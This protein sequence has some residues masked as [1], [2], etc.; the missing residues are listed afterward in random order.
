MRI[1]RLAKIQFPP[2][3]RIFYQKILLGYGP[4][5]KKRYNQLTT[6]QTPTNPTIWDRRNYSQQSPRKV[7]NA[8]RKYLHGLEPEQYGSLSD[9]AIDTQATNKHQFYNLSRIKRFPAT[10]TFEYLIS[11]YDLVV[12]TMSAILLQIIKIPTELIQCTLTTLQSMVHLFIIDFRNS[13]SSYAGDKWA[14]PLSPP[15]QGVVHGNG[16]SREIWAMV[17]TPLLKWLREMGHGA[18]FKCCLFGYIRKL[19]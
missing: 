12:H 18:V 2:V 9:K 16:F 14:V 3:H 11:N 15:P 13:I 7:C 4:Y 8:Q 10:S 5:H 1:N 19:L 17:S 6:S